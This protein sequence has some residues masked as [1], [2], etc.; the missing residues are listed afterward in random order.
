MLDSPEL[1][2]AMD[3]GSYRSVQFYSTTHAPPTGFVTF[4]CTTIQ[5]LIQVPPFPFLVKF[6]SLFS[7]LRSYVLLLISFEQP[8]NEDPWGTAKA[9]STMNEMLRRTAKQ[10]GGHE[11]R[12]DGLSF[13]FAFSSCDNA[14]AFSV[15][16]QTGKI[17]ISPLTHFP[18][19][20][21]STHLIPPHP[22]VR[23]TAHSGRN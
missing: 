7:I 12:N 21:H 4:V 3:D 17:I 15:R 9:I 13:L 19:T 20:I 11:V 6:S 1:R 14:L 5:H 10:F 16:V 22:P 18:N 23:H 2:N 8:W